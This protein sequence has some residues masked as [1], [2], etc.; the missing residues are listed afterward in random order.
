L[1]DATIFSHLLL[2]NN[3]AGLA[4][5]DFVRIISNMKA[6]FVLASIISLSSFCSGRA[7]E[8]P[9]AE[10]VLNQAKVE[11]SAGHKNIFLRFD[12]SW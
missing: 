1:K 7:E 2:R 10:K 4:N 12:A 6:A 3:Q 11:A 8:T 9:S 5:A